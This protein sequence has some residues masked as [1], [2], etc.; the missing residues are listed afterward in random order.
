M[1]VSRKIVLPSYVINDGSGDTLIF[2]DGYIIGQSGKI[3]QLVAGETLEVV[4]Y[5]ATTKAGPQIRVGNTKLMKNLTRVVSVTGVSVNKTAVSLNIG[6]TEAVIATTEP[7]D[8]TNTMMNWTSS[9]TNVATVSAT[10]VVKAIA[11]GEATITVETVDGKFKKEIQVTVSEPIPTVPAAP[12][13]NADNVNKKII[14]IDDTMEYNINNQS[15]VTYSA[16]NPPVLSGELTVE[17]R[18]KANGNVPAGHSTTLTFT[19]VK[20][21]APLTLLVKWDNNDSSTKASGGLDENLNKRNYVFR[22]YFICKC[23]RS[24]IWR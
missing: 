18:V 13:V 12:A 9:N 19:D 4:G 16:Q 10:G 15:W 24:Y 11:R 22:C 20:N 17:V 14:G 1:Q 7:E 2:I 23:C 8:A 3:P 21:D 6:E 5:T